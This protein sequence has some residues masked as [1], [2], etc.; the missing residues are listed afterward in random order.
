MADVSWIKLST[1]LPDNKKIKR[2]RKL[3]DGDKIILFWVFLLARAGESN[4]SGGL[5]L[6]ETLPYS[7]EDLA[8]DFD[9]SIEL[10][11]FA[12]LT[13]E[14]YGMITRYDEVLFIKNWEEHQSVDSMEKLKEQ[15]R[16]RQAKYR[17]KQKKLSISNV[18]DNV[19][20][21]GEVTVSNAIDIDK[22]LDKE[23]DIDKDIDINKSSISSSSN[24]L[25]IYEKIEMTC[26]KTF[27]AIAQQNLHE[28]INDYG[29]EMVSETLDEKIADSTFNN[30][31]FP[32]GVISYIRTVLSSKTNTDIQGGI[33][34]KSYERFNP[35][36]EAIIGGIPLWARKDEFKAAIKKN[37]IPH[38]DIKQIC[39]RFGYDFDEVTA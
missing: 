27:N 35:N 28:L 3:P 21:N 1:G 7:E 29:L 38:D 25:G 19:T 12:L 16:L 23:I 10:T 13:L 20:R 4:Q 5:F 6:T 37:Q 36:G 26:G 24:N 34:W 33:D 8:A 11:N 31:S 39:E 15:N 18:T 9:F 2:I 14:K 17:E 32:N 22:E 30:K